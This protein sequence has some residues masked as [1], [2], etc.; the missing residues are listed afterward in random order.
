M[1]K[2]VRF[3]DGEKVTYK[4]GEESDDEEPLGMGEDDRG[5]RKGREELEDSARKNPGDFDDY[6]KV[7][8][9]YEVHLLNF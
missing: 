6:V 3:T 9:V 1:Q 2:R 7:S 8:K 5:V 4:S